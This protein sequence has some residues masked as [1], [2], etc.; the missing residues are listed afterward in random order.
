MSRKTRIAIEVIAG[1]CLIILLYFF[2]RAI[3]TEEN[4]NWPKDRVEANSGNRIIMGTTVHAIAVANDAETGEKCVNAALAELVKVDELMS[5]YKQD[6]EISRVNREAFKHAVKVS[7]STFEVLQKSLEYSRLSSGAFDITVGPL[8]DLWHKAGESGVLPREQELQN[9]L[10]K[11]GFK[12]LLLDPNDNSVRFAVDGMSVNV[13]GIAKGYASDKAVEAMKA[14][15]AIGG[16]VASAGDIRCFGVPPKNSEYWLIGLQDPRHADEYEIGSSTLVMTLKMTDGAVSTSGDYR[17]F[18]TIGG[19]NYSHI[20]D[21]RNGQSCGKLT[22]VTIISSKYAIEADA[23]ATAVSGIGDE[24]GLEMLQSITGTEAILIGTKP[25]YPII[26]TEGVEK[27][28]QKYDQTIEPEIIQKN[29]SHQEADKMHRKYQVYKAAQT[30]KQDGNWSS[31]AWA[32]IEALNIENILGPKDQYRPKTQA[33]LLYDVD[34]I[35]V[36]F[37]VE[38]DKYIKATARKHQDPVFMDSCVEFFFTP[39]ED[40]SKGYVNIEVNCGGTVLSR[41]QKAKN[42]EPKPLTDQEIAQMNIYHSEPNIIESEKQTPATWVVE[43]RIPLEIIRKRCE[44][45]SPAPGVIW[46]ANLY[47]CGDKLS[48]PHWLTWSRID[49]PEPKFHLPEFFGTL[50]FE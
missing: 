50:E 14:G 48:H 36:I 3:S 43:Y 21:P 11:T 24:K 28:I 46:R 32:G 49:Y 2:T 34:N 23:L 6:S 20:I 19:K 15:G 41:H 42:V 30:P 31:G 7:R 39:G 37:R 17:R 29:K 1:I 47:K 33:K 45:T 9:A 13:G 27:Y 25:D 18:T 22:S 12:K 26:M 38:N 16:L 5:N 40:T 8:V 4:R 35:Y 10:S 44:V